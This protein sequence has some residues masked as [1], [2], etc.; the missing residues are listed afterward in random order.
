MAGLGRLRL[1]A[2]LALALML[3]FAPAAAVAGTQPRTAAPQSSEPIGEEVTLAEQTF[4]YMQGSGH[5]ETA[6]DTLMEALKNV[7]VLLE[8]R[9]LEAA[10]API[11]VYTG[12]DDSTFQ[13]KAGIPVAG[14]IDN[15]PRGD[16]AVGTTPAGKALKF[17]HRG[18]YDTI[19]VTYEAIA[20]FLDERNL[21]AGEIFVE[22]Y[23]NDPL[24]TPPGDLV[25]NIFV[26]VR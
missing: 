20:N 11:A 1:G 13:F 22:Q 3:A 2:I 23:V 19:D 4:V 17:V 7:Q 10:G 16:I 12:S 15:P 9:G 25:I 18:T 6:Y 21:D 5:W 8:R 26:P 24:T 14:P